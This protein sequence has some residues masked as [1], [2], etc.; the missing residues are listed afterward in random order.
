MH[1][2]GD[3]AA[4]SIG[5]IVIVISQRRKLGLREV[6]G[7]AQSCAA[8]QGHLMLG[9]LWGCYAILS[10]GIFE[11]DDRGRSGLGSVLQR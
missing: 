7:L 9:L 4:T 6:E 3:L 5:T 2:Q 8:Y 11:R 1:S 10:S